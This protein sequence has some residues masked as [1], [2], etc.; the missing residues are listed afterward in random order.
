MNITR[1][2][3]SAAV[4]T[5]AL[6]LGVAA[7]GSDAVSTDDL[8]DEVSTQLEAQV[9]QAP[10]SVDCPETLPAEEG[11]EV[12]CTLTNGGETI[13]MTLTVTTVEGKDVGFD[14]AVDDEPQS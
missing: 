2:S 14:I 4:L 13:G 7:C 12:R 5:A 8:E 6:A 9:G 10:D 3:A 11:A 1:N